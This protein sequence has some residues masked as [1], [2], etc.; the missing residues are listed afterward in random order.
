MGFSA[1]SMDESMSRKQPLAVLKLDVS[2]LSHS[3]S[4]E[5]PGGCPEA[6]GVCLPPSLAVW[7]QPNP[8]GAVTYL[9]Y[10]GLSY[11]NGVITL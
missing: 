6:W 8:N 10:G 2:L 3:T 5:A 7:L 9:Q 11:R 1:L 4:G